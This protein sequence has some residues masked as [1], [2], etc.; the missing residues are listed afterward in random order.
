[1]SKLITLKHLD[2]ALMGLREQSKDELRT[3]EIRN[4]Q[5]AVRGFVDLLMRGVELPEDV[6]EDEIQSA[7]KRIADLLDNPLSAGRH[8]H[9]RNDPDLAYLVKGTVVKIR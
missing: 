7:K 9:F 8:E 1:M 3:E 6:L 2:I 4:I 5:T